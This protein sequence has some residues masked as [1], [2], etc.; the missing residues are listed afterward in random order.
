MTLDLLQGLPLWSI[1]G[2]WLSYSLTHPP[3]LPSFPLL[4][5]SPIPDLAPFPPS[6]PTAPSSISPIASNRSLSILLST[7]RR[8]CPQ[9]PYTARYTRPIPHLAGPCS[10]LSTCFGYS[11]QPASKACSKQCSPPSQYAS[12]TG[13]PIPLNLPAIR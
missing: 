3:P 6:C 12:P 8:A 5:F 2:T 9:S 13:T 11:R 7:P 1:Y 10:N 4:L